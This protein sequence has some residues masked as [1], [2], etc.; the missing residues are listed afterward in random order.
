[1]PGNPTVG[2][3]MAGVHCSTDSIHNCAHAH[4]SIKSHAL[5]LNTDQKH[6][7]IKTMQVP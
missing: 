2:Q 5:S 1:M 3:T 7:T 6:S 4:Q